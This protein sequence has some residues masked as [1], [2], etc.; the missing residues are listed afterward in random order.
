MI[1]LGLESFGGVKRRFNEKVIG[2]QVLIDD[3]AHHPTEIKVTI[4]AARQNIPNVKSSRYFSRIRLHG[5][6]HS[7]MNSQKA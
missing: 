6:N 2:S 4:E 5:R 1:K 7:W 3:Y